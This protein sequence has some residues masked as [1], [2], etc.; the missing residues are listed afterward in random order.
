ME[1]EVGLVEEAETTTTM[2]AVVA[3]AVVD[4]EGEEPTAAVVEIEQEISSAT[5]IIESIAQIY[6]TETV[7]SPSTTPFSSS[8]VPISP[9]VNDDDTIITS[10]NNP[11]HD[12]TVVTSPASSPLVLPEGWASKVSSKSGKTFYFNGFTK[13]TAWKISDIPLN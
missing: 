13:Q 10:V 5:E 12:T 8:V 1:M 3:A 2:T 6:E 9:S 7:S 4:V 11:I